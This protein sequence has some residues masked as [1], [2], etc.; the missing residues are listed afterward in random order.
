M[1]VQLSKHY[2]LSPEKVSTEQVKE[3]LYYCKEKRGLSNSFINQTISAL[4][5][6]YQDVLAIEWDESLKIKRPRRQQRLPEILSKQEVSKLID[7]TPNPKHK[8]I[9][10]VLYSAGIRMDELL[11]P[12]RR[13][14]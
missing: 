7:L 2:Q 14:T 11:C 1:L 5:I 12:L 9:L 3:Y 10:A 4:K 13:L 8:A 6:L